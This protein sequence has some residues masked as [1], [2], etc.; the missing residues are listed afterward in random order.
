MDGIALAYPDLVKVHYSPDIIVRADGPVKGKV[1]A[2]SGL[3]A[4]TSG[5]FADGYWWVP[6]VGPILGDVIGTYMYDW[7][8]T[9]YL[10]A[11][12]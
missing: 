6:I 4:G 1:A 5:L 7:F 12:E 11:S 9:P 3:I 2:I 8:V 10:A